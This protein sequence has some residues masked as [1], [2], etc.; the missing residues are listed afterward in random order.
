MMINRI[1]KL[2]TTTKSGTTNNKTQQEENNNNKKKKRFSL[3]LKTAMIEPNNSDEL[4][5]LKKT[6]QKKN[7]SK[8]SSFLQLQSFSVTP[9]KRSRSMF[10]QFYSNDNNRDS[11]LSTTD[12]TTSSAILDYYAASNTTVSENIIHT[13]A[14]SITS[15]YSTINSSKTMVNYYHNTSKDENSKYLQLGIQFY[16]KGELEQASYYWKLAA[17]NDSPL[18]I[19]FY[20]LT[21]RH[22]WV[23]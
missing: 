2:L 8:S 3:L 1:K 18:G 4:K 10:G 6:K 22:G 9:L 14:V 23:K 13:A 21:L 17:E 20:G 15:V 7:I 16:E 11:I 12:D 5:T 19:F